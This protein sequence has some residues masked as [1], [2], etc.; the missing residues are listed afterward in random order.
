MSL[1]RAQNCNLATC[2]NDKVLHI[3]HEEYAF[4]V[5]ELFLWTF[6]DMKLLFKAV[7]Q[8]YSLRIKCFHIIPGPKINTE[9]S[10]FILQVK[11]SKPLCPTKA[12][13]FK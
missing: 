2:C 5:S 12:T 1:F 9:K 11:K 8:E 7:A 10:A 3:L 6:T 13:I 4:L